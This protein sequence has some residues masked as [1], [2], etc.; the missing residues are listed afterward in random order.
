[1]STLVKMC[2]GLVS[3][4]IIALLVGP[5]GI[6][7]LGQLNNFV[8]IILSFAG[9]GINNGITKYTSQYRDN[10]DR[11]SRYLSVGLR[12]TVIS[13]SAIGILLI[14]LAI[15]LSS[16][17]L[18]NPDYAVVF[19][20]FGFTLLLY[21]A[22][23]FILSVINGFKEFRQFVTVNIA[24]SIIGLIFTVS[25]VLL[26]HT[27]GALV[28]AVTYQSVVLVVTLL[29]VRK[30]A[31]M[32]IHT[33]LRRFDK[34]I[35]AQFLR[36]TLMTLVSALMLPAAQLLLRGYIMTE[37]S[38]TAAGWWEGM[39]RISNIYLMVVTSSF[40]VYYLP[41]LSEI[42][43]PVELRREIAKA[44]RIIAPLLLTGFAVIYLSRHFIVH[45]LF[46]DQFEPMTRLFI[47]QMTGDFFKISSWL[48]AFVM[49]AKAYT[50]TFIISE[51][52]S[53]AAYIALG[54]WL[55]KLNG[56]VGA[57][58]AHFIQYILYSAAM[59]LIFYKLLFTPHKIKQ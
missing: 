21:A 46:T 20:I 1:M 17:I 18:L 34:K 43:D 54:Y 39:C 41:R 40:S 37:I 59:V 29:I 35:A 11:L 32:N 12:L 30:A 38:D 42:T 13:G 2:T 33:L 23:N 31:W 28:A 51:I 27:T 49:I 15:P 55:I 45:I 53:A 47:W 24:G 6:A 36:Y 22:N 14:L 19:R 44:F 25:L 7:L 3:M 50:R 57:C 52:L 26:Y 4:K 48:V 16:V 56:V 5:A 9:G 8:S 58:Q 10:P